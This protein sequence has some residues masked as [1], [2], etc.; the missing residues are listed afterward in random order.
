MRSTKKHLMFDPCISTA[1]TEATN[2][3]LPLSSQIARGQTLPSDTNH[4]R[5]DSWIDDAWTPLNEHK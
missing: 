2:W 4:I 5:H 3:P 1:C